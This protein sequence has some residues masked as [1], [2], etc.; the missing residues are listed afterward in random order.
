MLCSIIGLATDRVLALDLLHQHRIALC[1]ITGIS[2]PPSYRSACLQHRSW[3]VPVQFAG[4]I[5]SGAL[6]GATIG[7]AGG[8]RLNGARLAVSFGRYRPGA[9]IEDA[10]AIIVAFLIAFALR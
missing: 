3:T 2:L 7:L 4:R 10:V 6:S 8:A 1:T 5:I 9:F